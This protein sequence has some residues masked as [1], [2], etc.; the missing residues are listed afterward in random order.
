MHSYKTSQI[1]L[2]CINHYFIKLIAIQES[3]SGGKKTNIFHVGDR[4]FTTSMR[5][6]M[7]IES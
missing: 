1:S 5:F 2:L 4:E 7:N 3:I 6:F